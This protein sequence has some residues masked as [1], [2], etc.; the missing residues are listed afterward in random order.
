M[1]S[2]DYTLKLFFLR[3]IF[4][5][6]AA[7]NALAAV[8]NVYKITGYKILIDIWEYIVCA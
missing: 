5:H 6:A 7:S 8:C 1:D 4:L 2:G 3:S